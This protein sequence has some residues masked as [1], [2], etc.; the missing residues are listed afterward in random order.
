MTD[1][2]ATILI[3]D[4]DS[5]LRALLET[6]LRSQGYLVLTAANGEEALAAVARRAPDLILLDILMPGL[7]GNEVARR[8]KAN[9]ATENIPI[10]IVTVQLDRAARL[11]GLNAGAEDFL[12]KPI[13]RDELW[14]RVRNLLRLKKLA[15]FHRD[16][17]STAEERVRR[18]NRLYAVLSGITS[19]IVRIRDREELFREACRIAVAEGEFVLARV[20]E[21]GANGKARIAATSESDASLFQRIVDAYNSDPENSQSMLALALRSDQPIVSNDVAN[22]Q[23]IPSRAAL[24]KDGNYALALLP[25]I[26]E[27]RVVGTFLLRAKDAGMFDDE[28]LRLLLDM[29][30]D[31]SFALDHISKEERLNYLAMYDQL[32]GLANR[33]LFL[34]R[35]SQFIQAASPTGNKV[36]LVTFDIVRLRTINESLGRPAGD[37]VIREMAERFAREVGK[38]EV[39]RIGA[40]QFVAVLQAIKGKSEVAR[41]IEAL[42]QKCFAE[43]FR[44]SG[45]ELRIAAK[46]GIALFPNDGAEAELLLRNAEAALVRAKKLGE[47]HLFYTSALTA[48]TG[49]QLTLEN[50]LRQA[51]EKEEFVLHYQPKVEMETRRI[52]GVE[53]LIRW[54]S[55]ELGLVPPMKFIPLMEETGLILDVGAWALDKAIEDHLRWV[56]LGLSVPRVA[57]NVSAIQLR[58]R[59]FVSITGAAL[60][61]GA[62]PPGID[63]EI[64]ESLVMED[65]ESNMQKLK[66]IRDLGLSIAID[67]FGTGYSSLGYLAKLPVQTLKIDRSFIIT[68]LSDPDTMTLVSTIISLAHS[69]R[70]KVVAEGVDREEQAKILKLLRC[71]E[72]QGYLFSRPIPFDQMTALLMQ[73]ASEKTG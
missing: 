40:D 69:L 42:W 50:R 68:M 4:D 13:D 56:K 31:M 35:L 63:L 12:T 67:D 18:L 34:E 2:A 3:V 15:D 14:L 46:A 32:T 9:P 39:A 49:E 28:E 71:D 37:A 72:M 8:L 55:P 53:A 10:I 21:F 47:Q 36:A 22:D 23:R 57:V 66:E 52:V 51:L 44:V 59:D 43:P 11:A 16:H 54:Q 6:L 41:R 17:S 5:D 64:T 29:V 20:I 45:A 48:R 25:I 38:A 60:K 58:R 61:R 62:M 30:S 19:A 7:D 65:I 1:P 24:T 73:G 27:K 33:T 26:L 70:L